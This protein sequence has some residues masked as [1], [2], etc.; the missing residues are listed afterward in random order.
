MLTGF[1]F[2]PFITHIITDFLLLT[3]GEFS[4]VM[5]G[6]ARVIC[7]TASALTASGILTFFLITLIILCPLFLDKL[8]NLITLLKVVAF[9]LMDLAVRPITFPNFFHG[10][11]FPAG[12]ARDSFLAGGLSLG[13]LAGTR[14]A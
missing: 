6:F 1:L 5:K 3:P 14:C 2:I 10:T 11:G 8:L 9:G 12:T 7:F 4:L 13:L